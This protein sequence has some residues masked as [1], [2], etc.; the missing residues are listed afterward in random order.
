MIVTQMDDL[1]RNEYYAKL[2]QV[3]SAASEIYDR[4]V[5]SNFINV[6]I[7]NRELQILYRYSSNAK[8]ILE[9]GCGT[10]E[11]AKRFIQKTGKSLQC[12]DISSGM[13]AFSTAKIEKAGLTKKFNAR[14]LE[15][16]NLKTLNKKFDMVYSFNG[17]F[18]TEP[19]ISGLVSSLETSTASGSV[20]VFS[21]RNKKC[22][23]E[24]I[25]YTLIGR[26]PELKYRRSDTVEVE[27]VGQKIL[28]R[29][30][31]RKEIIGLFSGKFKMRAVYG[32]GIV[33]P[34]YLAEKI[35]SGFLKTLI[36]KMD[37]FLSSMPIFRT[38][39]DETAYVMER[40]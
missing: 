22:L 2:D 35:R 7:R 14:R 29:Y 21:I 30:Y 19:D 9:I 27:V 23:G 26:R 32:L 40:R 25:I 31:S 11:E 38:L 39:G 3:F 28:S 33:I 36:S 8:N 16:H 18:N 17:A 4:K 6:N 5:L 12:I 15:A 37:L 34:P 1:E 24:S 10:G 20:L 13:V